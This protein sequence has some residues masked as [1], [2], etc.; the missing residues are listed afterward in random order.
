MISWRLNAI[1]K[2]VIKSVQDGANTYGYLSDK[3]GIEHLKERPDKF[4]RR[5]HKHGGN[6]AFDNLEI[7]CHK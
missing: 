7:E 5:H 6:D 4:D 3:L 2:I 1:R